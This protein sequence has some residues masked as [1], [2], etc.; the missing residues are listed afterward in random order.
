MVA[1]NDRGART[2]TAFD[3]I[4]VEGALNQEL[5]L[6]TCDVGLFHH[7][8]GG[9]LKAADE[10]TAD[11]FAFLF[12]V[13][14]SRECSHKLISN[15]KRDQSHTGRRHKVFL[16]LAALALAEQPVV[17]KHTGELVTDGLVDQSRR[18]SGVN[19]AGKTAD[20]Q[21]I[22]HLLTNGLNLAG[23]HMIAIP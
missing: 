19:A 18:H 2:A 4:G 7:L 22:A 17:H 10:F 11:N 3:N 20:H 15:I 6:T 1:L 13:V 23:N 8:C 9:L 21:V 12:R 14:H 5:H 16:H